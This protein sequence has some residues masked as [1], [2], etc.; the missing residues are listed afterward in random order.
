M[1]TT[2]RRIAV[3]YEPVRLAGDDGNAE[4][5]QQLVDRARSGD[6]A[7]F[8]K[9]YRHYVPRIHA[10][11]YHRSYS[12][13]MAEEVTAATFERAYRQIERFEWRGGGFGAWLF[14]IA[15][16]E[17]TDIYRRQQRSR[18]DRGQLAMG[19][20]H[21]PYTFD[22]VE[23]IEEGE[24]P[25]RRMMAALGTLNTKY[26]KAI[27]LRYLA[28]LSHEEAAEAMGVTKPVMAVTLTRALKALKKAMERDG[29][30]GGGDI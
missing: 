24:D 5:E 22:D 26:Q 15:A 7:A 8:T 13:E 4:L 10:F 21:N 19:A 17:L 3:D 28:G 2:L 23:R 9:L 30:A 27:S 14:R 6:E 12:R 18:S 1:A 29:N 20:L 16:N 25:A 11:A